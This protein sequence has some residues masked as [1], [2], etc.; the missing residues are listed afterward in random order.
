MSTGNHGVNARA[1]ENSFGRKTWCPRS[2]RPGLVAAMHRDAMRAR[3]Q[4]G[5]G[6]V[7]HRPRIEAERRHEFLCRS[8]AAD[9]LE[10]DSWKRH[11]EVGSERIGKQSRLCDSMEHKLESFLADLKIRRDNLTLSDDVG[12]DK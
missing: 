7:H 3:Q 2:L 4:H 9:A 8:T 10:R 12:I 5:A 6:G 1:A 11:G